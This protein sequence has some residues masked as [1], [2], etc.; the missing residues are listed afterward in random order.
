ML[1]VGDIG[2]TKTDLAVFTAE[3]GPRAPLSQKRFASADYSSLQAI[4]AEFLAEIDLQVTEACFAVAGPVVNG[5]ATLSNLPWT[6]EESA[7]TA[8]LGVQSVSLLNDVEAMAN[9]VPELRANELRTLREGE[10]V[11]GGVIALVAPGT[12]LGQA[13]LTWDGSRY[14]AHASEGGHTDFGPTTPREMELVKYM[15][16]RWGRVSFERVCA[17]QSIPDLYDFLKDQRSVPE[18]PAVGAQ[19]AAVRDRTPVIMAAA[20]DPQER[21]P[22]CL[23]ALNLFASILGATAGN[24]ALTVLATGGVYLGGGIVQRILPV[25]KGQGQLF[26]T[27]F[28]E[29]GRLASFLARVPVHVIAEPVALL[30]AAI[31]GLDASGPDS[32]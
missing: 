1:L 5:K 7:L 32:I 18:S 29:K 16:G 11:A 10:P 24:F 25:A 17:G 23:E 27:A 8:A 28:Q 9:A 20:F 14:Q 4:A 30:G 13:F 3:H 21:D 26:L 6:V 12:G 31:H 15:Q 2:G 22:L 19:L